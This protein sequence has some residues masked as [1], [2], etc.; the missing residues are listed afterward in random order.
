MS[1]GDNGVRGVEVCSNITVDEGIKKFEKLKGI[2]IMVVV[3]EGD[4][5]L[6]E[7][8]GVEVD[9]DATVGRIDELLD[10]RRRGTEVEFDT[11]VDEVLNELKGVA[12]KCDELLNEVRELDSVTDDEVTEELKELKGI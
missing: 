11:R 10:V 7:A 5:L 4:K 8:R 3:S 6:I 9:F 12:V 2:E 1:E